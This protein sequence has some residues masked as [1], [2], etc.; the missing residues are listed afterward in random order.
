MI[1]ANPSQ[2]CIGI[3]LAD[4]TYETPVSAVLPIDV[5]I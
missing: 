1:E 2:N 4:Y 5:G 3:T